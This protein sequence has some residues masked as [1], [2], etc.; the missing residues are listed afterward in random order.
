MHMGK[1]K[2]TFI[3][4]LAVTILLGSLCLSAQQVDPFY[5]NLLEKAEKSFI[6]KNYR[7][8][9]R[10]FEIAAFGLMVNKSLQAKAKVYIGLCRYYLNDLRGSE[11]SLREAA[12]LIGNQGFTSL[13]IYESAWPDLDKLISFFNL[14]RP[15][16]QT[17]PRKV[18]KPPPASPLP[19]GEN[20]DESDKKPQEKREPDTAKEVEA[21]A[22]PSPPTSLNIEE[23]KEGD[24][25]PLDLIETRPELKKKVPAV[26]PAYARPLR[27]EGTV[28][29]DALISEKGKVIE[30]EVVQGIPNAVGFDQAALKAVRQWKFEPA[31]VKGIK[32]RVWIR[33]AVE[34][35]RSSGSPE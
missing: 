29:I 10:D 3:A 19:K 34:F 17:L 12:D 7:V 33:V 27:I 30:T 25:L 15:Q 14:A 22:S 4:T 8:A 1:R 21:S 5:L 6:A 11:K 16:D 31:T 28:I 23:L 32:V 18:E 9:A 35:K 2:D 13:L 24:L 26:Y 20:P